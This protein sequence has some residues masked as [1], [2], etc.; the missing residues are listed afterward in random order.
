[1]VRLEN[2]PSSA[3][4]YWQSAGSD[5]V[6]LWDQ[7]GAPIPNVMG[8]DTDDIQRHHRHGRHVAI[9]ERSE[10]AVHGDGQSADPRP[11]LDGMAAVTAAL[12][13]DVGA[14]LLGS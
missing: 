5:R 8:G 3:E 14:V 4:R 10:D 11:D 9:S 2:P 13:N 6:S 1:M 12:F 7:A